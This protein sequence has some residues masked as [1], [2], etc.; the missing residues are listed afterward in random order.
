M[1]LSSLSP[2]EIGLKAML[3]R[4]VQEFFQSVA[5]FSFPDVV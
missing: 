5:L 2:T 4:D 1:T 3:E